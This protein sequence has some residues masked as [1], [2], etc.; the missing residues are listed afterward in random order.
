VLLLRDVASAEI[1]RVGTRID[2]VATLELALTSRP[3]VPAMLRRDVLVGARLREQQH[4][5]EA[6]A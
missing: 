1:L 2:M 4:A 5:A 3:G 6:G